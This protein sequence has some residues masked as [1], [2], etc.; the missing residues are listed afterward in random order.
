MKYFDGTGALALDWE[1]VFELQLFALN[2]NV[3]TANSSGN[4]LTPD[5]KTYYEKRLIEMAEPELIFDQFADKYPIPK[6]AGKTIEFRKFAS[7]GKALTPLTEG[8][9]PNGQNLDV[10]AITAETSQYG[11]YVTMSDLLELTAIDPIV[12]RATR[13]IA[14]QAGQ[15][16]DTVTRN[17]IIA[18]TNVMYAPKA[19]GTAI[20]ARANVAADC[21]MTLSMIRK[22][23]LQLRRY[24]A[25]KFDG[26]YVCIVH[27][28]VAMD[29]REL[30]GWTD[31]TKYGA[32]DRIYNG[33]IGTVE[34]VR[35]I[36]NT[37]SKVFEDAGASSVN[38]Y[39]S[40][41]IGAG[42]YGTTEITGGGLQH[43]VKQKGSAG[44]EDPLDQRSTV[45]WKATKVSKILIPEYRVR[46]E[47]CATMEA[48]AIV[49]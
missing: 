41:F 40:L 33:E 1:P 44:T 35:F 16:L 48:T 47:S 26:Y 29:I 7:L 36:E 37:E 18:G 12:V 39:A 30:S 14:T 46:V 31:I 13:L 19:N 4:H 20:N 8:A 3:T 38:V 11:G 5:I 22:A 34:G 45:G 17:V 9:T 32:P 27:P 21:T 6:G 43:F 42:A 24:N 23:R 10:T 25:P 2:T 15:T 49:N 28:D